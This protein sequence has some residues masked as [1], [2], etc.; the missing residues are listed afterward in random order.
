MDMMYL[1][2]AYPSPYGH[3][4]PGPHP[5]HPGH[6]AG[7]GYH[8]AAHP[9][10]HPAAAD[11]YQAAAYAAKCAAQEAAYGHHQYAGKVEYA[12]GRPACSYDQA[13][14]LAAIGAHFDYDSLGPL[15]RMDPYGRSKSGRAKGRQRLL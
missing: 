8:P 3:G 1:P 10:H 12:G 2:D 7:A 13:V 9:A 6:P 15:A 11:P 14:S 5:G 4:G